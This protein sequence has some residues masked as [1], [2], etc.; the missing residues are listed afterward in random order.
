MST[1]L[2]FR[3]YEPTSCR[4]CARYRNWAEASGYPD[5]V[6]SLFIVV[7][8]RQALPAISDPIF[9]KK[10]CNWSSGHRGWHPLRN[11]FTGNQPARNAGISAMFRVQLPWI[12]G[13]SAVLIS[14]SRRP[15][16]S[17]VAEVLAGLRTWAGPQSRLAIPAA[18]T[19]ASGPDESRG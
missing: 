7:P 10:A 3:G 2:D 8:R 4:D 9:R 5:L 19:F 1:S 11:I 6:R 14:L 13:T 16:L 15:S 12:D 17:A 18:T